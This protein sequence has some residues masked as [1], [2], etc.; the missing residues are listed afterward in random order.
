MNYNQQSQRSGSRASPHLGP[1]PS[2]WPACSPHRGF[3]RSEGKQIFAPHIPCF[4][5][6]FKYYH[7]SYFSHLVETFH[8]DIIFPVNMRF[9][10]IL[11]SLTLSS[12]SLTRSSLSFASSIVILNAM[13]LPADEEGN[14]FQQIDQLCPCWCLALPADHDD[15]D[16]GEHDVVP[17]NHNQSD[18]QWWW[19]CA[20][21]CGSSHLGE[22]LLLGDCW[23]AGWSKE[24]EEAVGELLITIMIIIRMINDR[25]LEMAAIVLKMASRRWWWL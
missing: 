3:P 4:D 7:R 25:M 15:D 18:K 20:P 8:C 1:C 13:M 12:L 22:P 16:T 24:G 2:T 14:C 6:S 10:S 9:S 19:W 11:S 23:A 5:Q 17:A 21:G